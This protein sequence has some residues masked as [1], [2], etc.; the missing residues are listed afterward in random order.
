MTVSDHNIQDGSTP[1]HLAT[2]EGRDEICRFLIKHGA[3][4]D[5][6]DKV[7]TNLHEECVKVGN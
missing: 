6:Q 1:L 4:V 2:K 5:A 7:K 3:H